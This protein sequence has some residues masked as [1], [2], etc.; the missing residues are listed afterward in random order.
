MRLMVESAELDFAVAKKNRDPREVYAYNMRD[1]Y[2]NS[3]SSATLID[4]DADTAY[5]DALTAAAELEDWG[6]RLD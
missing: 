2:S 4:D 5:D 1:F 6:A 3:S